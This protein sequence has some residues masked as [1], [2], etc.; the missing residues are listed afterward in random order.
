[1]AAA[2]S[3]ILIIIKIIMSITRRAQVHLGIMAAIIT[4]IIAMRHRVATAIHTVVAGTIAATDMTTI[5]TGMAAIMATIG[6]NRNRL[7]SV[8]RISSISISTITSTIEGITSI[9]RTGSAGITTTRPNQG[10]KIYRHTMIT[11]MIAQGTILPTSAGEIAAKT[12][13]LIQTNGMRG[14]FVT[15]NLLQGRKL[16]LPAMKTNTPFQEVTIIKDTSKV[17]GGT[18]IKTLSTIKTDLV[19]KLIKTA[20]IPPIMGCN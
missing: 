19:D 15:S 13:I 10:L 18:I 2:T 12:I 8:M 14:K 4:T 3:P 20:L 17:I 7:R 16:T 6:I 9:P 5:Q 11:I 1:M